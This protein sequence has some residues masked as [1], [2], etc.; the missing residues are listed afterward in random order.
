MDYEQDK[1]KQES[2]QEGLESKIE[3]NPFNPEKPLSEIKEVALEKGEEKI[4]KS[5]A[6]LEFNLENFSGAV[7][8]E[9]FLV[10][11]MES[12]KSEAE[13]KINE[14]GNEFKKNV[15]E[16]ADTDIEN[17]ED[18]TEK[19]TA[20]IK[21]ESIEKAQNTK[22]EIINLYKELKKTKDLGEKEKISSEI[23]EKEGSL[24]EIKKEY[25]VASGEEISKAIFEEV[26]TNPE[27]RSLI[28]LKAQIKALEEMNEKMESGTI[29][30]E[31]H[32]ASKSF[33]AKIG[34]YLP[35]NKL[36]QAALVAGVVSVGAIAASGGFSAGLSLY[37]GTKIAT[38]MGRSIAGVLVGEK[39]VDLIGK[40]IDKSQEKRE[41]KLLSENLDS[42]L[43]KIVE[44][45]N[46][47][48]KTKQKSEKIKKYTKIGAHVLFAGTLMGGLEV[49]E[50]GLKGAVNLAGSGSMFAE[51]FSH[52][53]KYAGLDIGGDKLIHKSVHAHEHLEH[54]KAA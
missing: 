34:K 32:H 9:D 54:K 39:I 22:K 16:V 44:I 3:E 28:K 15:N 2:S 20:E 38:K 47:K 6:E 45:H 51:V 33:I 25:L 37:L 46:E 14:V 41:D 8:N 43:D 5:S 12:I 42:S 50:A 26:K 40:G 52:S 21:S 36:A 11:E 13:E 29:S 17:K 24:N 7:G 48:I 1:N 19:S 10:A 18:K 49:A 4:E 35:K 31:D 27:N 23:K 30:A 53:V